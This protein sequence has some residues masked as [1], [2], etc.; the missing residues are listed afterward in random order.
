VW[1]EILVVGADIHV[2]GGH[3]VLPVRGGPVHAEASDCEGGA[4]AEWIA[5]V[6]FLPLHFFF[7]LA[8]FFSFRVGAFLHHRIG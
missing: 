6:R 3:G 8:I 2:H 5:F 4:G 7:S 1:A